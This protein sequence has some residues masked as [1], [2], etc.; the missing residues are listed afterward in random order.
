MF[1]TSPHPLIPLAFIANGTRRVPAPS[2]P[3]QRDVAKTYSPRGPRPQGYSPSE[4]LT[5][6]W[7]RAEIWSAFPWP[8]CRFGGYRTAN[9]QL[10]YFTG[11]E[12]D[13]QAQESAMPINKPLTFNKLVFDEGFSSRAVSVR[14]VR[15]IRSAVWR[16]WE[17]PASG[18]EWRKRH[19]I[20]RRTVFPFR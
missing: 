16:E 2:R 4:L 15:E 11:K 18:E 1:R 5:S 6:S 20:W 3:A 8:T 7:R 13:S 10:L 19:G 17:S 14:F 12:V 9:R